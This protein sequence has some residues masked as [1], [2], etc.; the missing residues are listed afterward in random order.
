MTNAMAV[1]ELY[2]D[3]KET[4]EAPPA[5]VVAR[6]YLLLSEKAQR[7]VFYEIIEHYE[8]GDLRKVLKFSEKGMRDDRQVP[9]RRND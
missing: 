2:D 8:V 1:H 7:A 4:G 3:V 6:L 9:S 5:D